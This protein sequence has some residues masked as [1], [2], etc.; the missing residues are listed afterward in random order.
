MLLDEA[1][2]GHAHAEVTFEPTLVAR[3]STALPPSS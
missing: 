3:G 2:P 1:T